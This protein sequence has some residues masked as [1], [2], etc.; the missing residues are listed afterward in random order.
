MRTEFL[1]EFRNPDSVTAKVPR[2]DRPVSPRQKSPRPPKSSPSADGRRQFSIPQDSFG[3]SW[4]TGWGH[5]L[6]LPPIWGLYFLIFSLR[7][8]L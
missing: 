8:P 5:L 6:E 4:L 1:G 2:R 7:R 3:K